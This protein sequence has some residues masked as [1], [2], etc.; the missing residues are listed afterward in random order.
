ME[1]LKTLA[2]QCET[3]SRIPCRFRCEPPIHLDDPATALHLFRIAQEAVNNAVRH[4]QPGQ[5]TVSLGQRAQRLEI[6]VT[7]DGRGL[8]EVPEGHAGIGLDSMRQR[9]RLLGGDCLIQAREG[10]GT[11]VRCWVPL[12][13]LRARTTRTHTVTPSETGR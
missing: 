8:G 11:V 7:D 3:V 9:A 2:R 1:A 4:G 6:V 10:G 12:P 5:I 13:G